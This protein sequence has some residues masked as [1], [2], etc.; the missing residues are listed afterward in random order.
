MTLI[1][2]ILGFS[3]FGFGARCFQLGLQ[4][5]PIFDAPSGHLISTAVFGAV[6]YG[7]YHADKKQTALLAEK[8]KVLLERREKENLEW[9]AT[10]GQAQGHA[11]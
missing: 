8:K 10:R 5:R 6:G 3:A 11:V 4:H 9:E 7:A 1:S 2:T